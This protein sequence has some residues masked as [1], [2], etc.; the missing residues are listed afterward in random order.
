MLRASLGISHSPLDEGTYRQ[1]LLV[2]GLPAMGPGHLESRLPDPFSA[3][4]TVAAVPPSII[5]ARADLRCR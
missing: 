1:T 5:R 2:D 4:V 3:G